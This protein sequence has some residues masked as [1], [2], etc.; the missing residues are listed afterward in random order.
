MRNIREAV[1]PNPS[2]DPMRQRAPTQ[3][4]NT[5]MDTFRFPGSSCLRA[6]LLRPLAFA[7]LFIGGP[8]SSII[9]QGTIT[10][11]VTNAA[12]GRTLEGARIVVQ[13]SGHEVFSDPDGTF[14]LND[15]PAGEVTLSVSYT[16][17]DTAVISVSVTPGATKRIDAGLTSEIYRLDKFVVAGEREGNAL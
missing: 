13:G 14:R 5:A 10:G 8:M 11:T 7:A 17:L 3:A 15:L 1:L 6:T 4:R 9:A 12:T 16:G 2:G